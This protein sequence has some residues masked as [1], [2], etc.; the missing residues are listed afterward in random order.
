MSVNQQYINIGSQPNDGTGDSIYV[1]FQ[2]VNS[3]FRDIYTLLGFGSGFS[4]LR[5]KEAP[6]LL[7]PGA[8]LQV[9][10]IGTKF[11]NKVLEG[12]EGIAI[13]TTSTADKIIVINT[14]SNLKSDRN[15][16]LVADINGQNAFSLINMDNNGPRADWDAVSRKWVYENFVNRDGITEYDS[17]SPAELQYS[18]RSIIRQNV[19][20]FASPSSSTH[21]VTKGYVD[22]LAEN[23]GYASRTNFFVALDGDDS[24]FDI[25]SSKRG[26]AFAFAFKTINRAAEAAEQFIKSSQIVLGPYQKTIT[27]SNGKIKSTVSEI[28]SSTILPPSSF[29]VRLRVTLDEASRNIGTDPFIIKSIFPGNYIIGTRS[30]A[31][32]LVEAIRLDPVNGY[33]YYDLTPVDYAETFR[34]PLT[35]NP[36]GEGD[37]PNIRTFN[38]GLS[39]C[40]DIPDFWIGYKFTINNNSNNIISYG[41]IIRIDTSIDDNNNVCDSITVDFTDGVALTNED[42]IDENN[43]HVYSSD[44]ELGE[45]MQWGQKQVLNQCTIVVESGEHE[46]Q[47]PI[48]LPDNC[49]IRGDEFR[50]TVVKPAPLFGT[51][52]PAISASKWANTFFYRDAQIDGIITVQ[53]DTETDFAPADSISID[54]IANDPVTDIVTVTL[55]TGTASASW[56]G[57]IFKTSGDV[58]AIGEIRAVNAGTFAVSLAQN[59]AYLRQVTGYTLGDDI[60]AGD[61]HIYE[62]IKYGYHYLRDAKRPVNT[63]TTATNGGGY[64]RAATLLELN[65]RFIQAEVISHINSEFPSFVYDEQKC[66]RDVGLIVDALV[67]DL[68]VGGNNWTINA[69]DTYKDVEEIQNNQLA[70]TTEAVEHINTLAQLII[71]NQAVPPTQEEVIQQYTE[72]G[73]GNIARAI[74]DDLIRAYVRI[75]N[76]DSDFNPPKYNEAMDVFLMNDATIIRYVSAQGHSGFMKVLDPD[77]QILAKS[78]YTQTASS[79]S[80]SYN[81]HVFSGGMFVDGFSGNTKARTNTVTN[82]DE[83]NPIKISTVPGGLGRPSVVPGEGFIKPQVPCFFVHRGI[84]HEVS[85]ISEWNPVNGTGIMNLN[86]LRPGGVSS[87]T[88]VAGS[89]FRTG[90]TRT[91]PVRFT[92][93]TRPGGLSATGTA[94]I[95]SS[96][97]VTAITV[98]FP[99]GGYENG[100]YTHSST[101]GPKISIGGA[102]ISWTL[103]TNGSV[104]GY[105]IIDAG[106]GYAIGTAI[107]FP[108]SD[109]G[110]AT[111]TVS[112]IGANG[113]ITAVT[114]S[115]AGAGY[116]N[117][118]PVTFGTGVTYAIAIK[119]GFI[120]TPDHPLPA[121][122]VLVT[123][124][125]RSMLAND[126]TQMN[127][128]GYGVFATNGGFIENVSMFTYYCQTSYYALNGA[129]LRTITG[130]SAYG[131]FG[132]IAEGSDPNEVPIPVRNKFAM[133]QL[134]TV[135][136]TAQY[137]NR[138]GDFTIYVTGLSYPPIAQ[139][140]IEI[141]HKG[142]VQNYNVKSALQDTSDSSVYSLSI[143]D[144]TGKGLLSAV[145]DG[146]PVIIRIYF[147]Q[148]LLDVNPATLGRPSTVLT[149]NEDP[150]NVYRVLNYF[151]QGAD[152]AL[153][154]S[155]TP[156]NYI[157]LTPYTESGL[158]RQ[159]L[160]NIT[161][162]NGGSGYTPGAQITASIPA[163]STAGTASVNGTQSETDLITISGATGTIMVGSRVTLTSGGGDPNSAPTYVTWVNA[164]STQIRVDRVWTWNNGVGLTFS[165]TQAAGYGLVNAS[166]VIDK[167]VLT[168]QGAGYAGTSTRNIT[169][170]S[171]SATATATPVGIVGTKIIKVIDL[172]PSDQARITTGLANGYNY[173][174]GFEG[175]I[176]KIIGYKNAD[177]TGNLWGEVEVD[178]LSDDAALQHTVLNSTIKAGIT[179]N[180]PG[181]ITVRISTLRATSHDMVDVGTGGYAST[182]IPND[183]YGPPLNPPDRSKEVQEKGRGR[184]YYVTTDQDGNFNV[185]TFFGVDQGRGTVSISAP[186]SLTNVDGISFRRGQSLVQQFTV[187]GTLG[188]NSNNAVPTERAIVS[189]VNNR[190][191]LNRNNTTAGV[192]PIGSGFLDRG[193]VL[194][195]QANIKM[196]GNRIT[197]MGDPVNDQDAVTRGWLETRYV[198]TS[199]DTMIG[200]LNSQDIVSRTNLGYNLGGVSNRYLNVYANNF[201]GTATQV[202]SVLTRGTYLTGNNYNGSAATTWAVDATNLNTGDKVVARDTSGSFRAGVITAT[203]FVGNLTG[204]VTGNVTGDLSGSSVTVTGSVTTPSIV[205]SGTNGSGD[206]GQTGN[207]FNMIYGT[208]SSAQYADLAEKYLPDAEY[209]PGTVVIFGGSK[210]IT[211]SKKF[212]D[213]RIA[214]VISTAPAYR[215][216]D[217][218]EGGVHVALQG[219]VPCKVI[220]KI[221]KGDMLISSNIPGVATSEEHPALGSVIGKALENYDSDEVGVIEVVVGR[222]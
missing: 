134:A 18:G 28:T 57:K 71:D 80:K 44:F 1:A 29:G 117:D 144:G 63:L 15:P 81:R 100:A 203:T 26:R 14:A 112:G 36:Q 4:F 25:P 43:W 199:G 132:L 176:Y 116:L 212:M 160:G 189:Y 210:E 122:V 67:N 136:S 159:G 54:G 164:T 105:S 34:V 140:Q 50:R 93:P 215:M 76:S 88:G 121:E 221:S 17:T 151:D 66:F 165:G 150:T 207:R 209:E 38:L 30:K 115:N 16:T 126:F 182:K 99:G 167:V 110:T 96:G 83:G 64:N 171:G 47:Y 119:P 111:A 129:I 198:N 72:F 42:E 45:E 201:L 142:I 87:V 46:D 91:I 90:A 2:K 148:L 41:K 52:L 53:L 183:L 169:F 186:I 125:N 49:S 107:N 124:G 137:I 218:Q 202:S 74:V 89:G 3:N 191:G 153:A 138:D 21:L 62:P 102:R 77:G 187:D 217:E 188:G 157:L 194:D 27:H 222:I 155:N 58:D 10:D 8:I 86:P 156:Y 166:G 145:A 135:K 51:R 179:S 172:R 206:I 11:I 133:N 120:V 192:N 200:T 92:T 175:H 196:D 114:I 185:G 59:S 85:F 113:E 20:S 24:R 39:H 139:S 146:E 32:G 7:V 161:I 178:R 211:Q 9:N 22:N 184:V 6:A 68:K 128:L 37:N 65:R 205:K 168:N 213:R 162:T 131:S 118:P 73:G 109:Q 95:N 143:D 197:N 219:R 149:F 108:T 141:N 101:S 158:Y 130:S 12:G 170:A 214:G 193:G 70:E 82:D 79:F 23:S 147:N 19:S 78:P 106:E 31:I 123:A 56:I 61:W 163:P 181:N 33:E 177:E 220:G 195:M 127:D 94:T 174:F 98:G 152:T 204:N 154:E 180:Q 75:L 5:L 84:S 173:T 60:P 55:S 216:N 97:Q 208:A 40:I 103:N 69:A 190:L 13:D 48:K 35:P 104:I